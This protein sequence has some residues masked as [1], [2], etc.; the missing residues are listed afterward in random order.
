[1]NNKEFLVLCG[2][3]IRYMMELTGDINVND[4][5]TQCIFRKFNESLGKSSYLKNRIIE[6]FTI[7]AHCFELNDEKLNLM[8]NKIMTFEDTRFN[9]N[10]KISFM[11]GF[12]NVEED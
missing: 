1:M 9:N 2:E 8:L 4:L 5:R 7:N 10:E 6:Y 3:T 11:T 12:T